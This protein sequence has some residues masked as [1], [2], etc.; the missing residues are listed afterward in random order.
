MLKKIAKTAAM[1]L[2]LLVSCYSISNAQRFDGGLLGGITASQ[3]DGD[4]TTGYHKPGVQFGGFVQTS[5]SRRVFASMELKYIQ[6]GSRKSPGPND[7]SQEKYIMRLG[8]IDLPVFLG[9]RTAERISF[10]FGAS[11]GVLMHQGEWDNYGKIPT[12][13]ERPFNSIDIQAFGGL[14]VELTNRIHADLRLAYS[15][16]PMREL[17][18]ESYWY[19]WD[20]EFN[21]LISTSVSYR[22]GRK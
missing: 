5:L 2:S 11:L 15:V 7:V 10:V 18:G 20:D 3:V 4:F 6:K 17:P 8:Y 12:I 9:I 21:H 19:W 16:V 14:R 1:T 22:L 13:E